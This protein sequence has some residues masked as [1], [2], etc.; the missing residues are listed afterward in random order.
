MKANAVPI[1]QLFEKKLRLEVPLFQRQYVWTR[2]HQWEPLWEDISR[3]FEEYLN[4]R[5]D[6]PVHFLGAMVLDQRQTPVTHVEK[7]QVIDGQQRLTTLQIFLSAF[8]DFCRIVDCEEHANELEGF[9]LNRGMMPEPD[10]DKFKVWPTQLDRQQFRD[11]IGLMSRKAIE[12]KYPLVRRKRARKPDPRPTMVEAYLYFSDQISF[13]FQG[14]NG[15]APLMAEH[16][17]AA[18]VDETFQA[19]KN[20]LQVV[21]IDL[22]EGDDAQV[23]FET[24]NAR[25]EPLLPADLLRNY[26]FLRAA[27]AG[28]AHEVL[29]EKYWRGF[30]EQ[31]WREEVRQGRLLRPRS[32]LFMQ[33]YL[34][35]HQGVDVPVKHLFTEYRYWIEKRKPFTSI[36]DELS[37]I[38][39][40]R[41]H[42]R[43]L[44]SPKRDD[45]VFSLATFLE[46]FDVRTLYPLL[47]FLLEMKLGEQDWRSVSTTLESYV[48]RRSLLGLSTKAYNRIFLTIAK[49][50]RSVSDASKIPVA[51]R[52]VL[53]LL[54]GDSSMWPRD[55]EFSEA[56]LTRHAYRDLNQT[57]IVHIL[58]RLNEVY[59]TPKNETIVLSGPLTIEH[60]LPQSWTAHWPLSDGSRGLDWA[61]LSNAE[62]DDPVAIMT[63][64]RN[65]ALQTFGNLT[66]L[67]QELN[68]SVSAS[69]FS[70]KKPAMLSMSLL[71]INQQLHKYPVWNDATIRERG[72]ELL[73]H[74]VRLW[75]SPD[76]VATTRVR[77][78]QSS[79]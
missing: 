12:D 74:A 10:V 44:L 27:R 21:T 60:I 15:E 8:R 48:L 25:G 51:L 2:E 9:T 7:R 14:T 65:S 79:M 28:E 49:A 33:H 22:D 36:D 5:K 76:A 23:I 42:F 37:T 19:L 69:A 57:R 13:F 63:R 41:E 62:H 56:W 70:K 17:I 67:T 72:E 18:R 24:L 75:P 35:S 6:A 73:A 46:D 20:T 78:A 68:S 32:D 26:I 43:R 54:T 40:Q 50:L 77:E 71:P 59:Y 61:E 16:P 31:F 39:R 1:L 52:G 11:V 47:L 4:G 29:Y 34:S 55:A 53:S 38:A 66:L 3:K 58:K 45:P 30:D 64:A